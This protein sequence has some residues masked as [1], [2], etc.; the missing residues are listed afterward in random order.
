MDRNLG[1]TTTTQATLTT[2]GLHYQ[3]GRKDPFPHADTIVQIESTR[4]Y[5]MY[6]ASGTLLTQGTPTG[7]S[8]I[9]YVNVFATTEEN[10]LVNLVYAVHNPTTFLRRE[11]NGYN[12]WYTL[13]DDR[14]YQN[15]NLWGGAIL[16]TPG[17]KT[18]FDPC[19]PG[20]RVPPIVNGYSP[21]SIFGSNEVGV[22]VAR[23]SIGDWNRGLMTTFFTAGY[24]PA[25]GY[26]KGNTDGITS[27]YATVGSDGG[28]LSGS[29]NNQYGI[30]L[31]IFPSLV[32]P[33]NQTGR[34]H[35]FPVRCVKE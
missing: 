13:T 5:N 26:I 16:T 14:S 31:R 35:G 12:D 25:S 4:G 27:I 30:M 3:W 9:N 11:T 7:G 20:W 6:N 2:L 22:T 32:H 28:L 17:T 24:I 15:D 29:I 10:K 8:G 33:R 19:P 21:W 34:V 23:T 1:A 18:V